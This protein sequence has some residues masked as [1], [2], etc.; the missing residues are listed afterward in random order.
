MIA[1][2][3]GEFRL[4]MQYDTAARE[5]GCEDV[6]FFPAHAAPR[7]DLF[8][9]RKDFLLSSG[10]LSQ[11]PRYAAFANCATHNDRRPD[12]RNALR[13]AHKMG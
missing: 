5:L 1:A 2:G 13:H 7:C 12:L 10:H 3:N 4:W 9:G 6:E 8:A 11:R